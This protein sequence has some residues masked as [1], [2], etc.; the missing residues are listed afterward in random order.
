VIRWNAGRHSTAVY[1]NEVFTAD[2]AAEV[3][4]LHFLTDKVSEPYV[5]RRIQ[6]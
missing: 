4:Y 3:F 5:L 1:A 2:E 6:V